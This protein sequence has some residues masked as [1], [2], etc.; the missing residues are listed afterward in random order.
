MI[1]YVIDA[2]TNQKFGGNPAGVVIH[3][4]A[5]EQFMQAFAAEVRFSET[6]F[7]KQ[8]DSTTFEV[9]FFT[10]NTEVD[11][12]GH[13]T[14]AAFKALLHQQMIQDNSTYYMKTAAGTLSIKIHQSVITMEQ[15]SPILGATFENINELATL[16]HIDPS[17]IGCEQFHLV[18][19]AACT[20]LWDIMLPIKTKEAL[21]ALNPDFEAITAFTEKHSVAGIHAF[22]LDTE[23][24][25][26]ESR[27]FCPRY[28]INEE[29]AT[30]TSTG[31][32][33]YFLAENNVIQKRNED[34]TFLQGKSMGRP[35]TIIT[36]IIMDKLPKIMVGGQAVILTKGD[37][38]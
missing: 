17:F 35:S 23:D 6:A 28:D 31:A 22:T 34:L 19:Q 16:F 2:F 29:A 13:A 5:D 14:I 26:A 8:L 21:Y 9:R 1:Y 20:G 10:P 32:L 38:Y 27:N 12:C 25:I 18:P 36:K 37:I 33:T 3:E 24:A 15:G 30:G 11:L 7:V 4:H